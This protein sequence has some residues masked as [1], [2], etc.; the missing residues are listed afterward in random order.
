[1][2]MKTKWQL[3]TKVYEGKSLPKSRCASWQV[4]THIGNQRASYLKRNQDDRQDS[5]LLLRGRTCVPR[6]SPG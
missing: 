1:M 3:H 6:R 5:N 4:K 2:I